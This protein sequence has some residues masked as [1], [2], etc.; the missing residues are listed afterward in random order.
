MLYNSADARD[1]FLKE[2]RT[3]Y[4]GN[5]V[6]LAKILEFEQTYRAFDA[7]YWY[8]RPDF[9]FRII[10]RALRSGDTLILFK[11][12]YFLV[13]MCKNLEATA[14]AQSSL[15][16]H[17]YRGATLAK[18][19]VEQLNVGSRIAATS[20]F[21]SSSNIQV[22]RSF[23][24]IDELTGML[25]SRSRNDKH[26]FVLFEIAVKPTTIR[27]AD[28]I[29]ANVSSQSAFPEEEEVLFGLGT[30]FDITMIEYDV[31]HY[32]WNIKM[33]VSSEAAAIKCEQ[34]AFIHGSLRSTTAI[35]LFGS[36]LAD[37]WGQYTQ[38]SIYFHDLL[39]T[40]STDHIDRPHIFYQLGRVYRFLGKFETAIAYLRC[41]QLFQRRL[42]PQ[43][44]LDYGSTLG[45]LGAT[46]SKVGD[47]KRAVHS[48]HL[49]KYD[50]ALGFHANRLASACYQEKQ[51]ERALS[52]LDSIEIVFNPRMS[53]G[54]PG[55]AQI[56]HTRALV[57]QALGD[58]ER[59]LNYLK[60]ALSMRES[61]LSKDHP[62]VARTCYQLALLYEE[63]SEYRLAFEH[64]ERALRIQELKL[65]KTHQERI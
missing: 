32:L 45:A 29:V 57:Y 37:I 27:S 63:R 31:E 28:V 12:R 61:W 2:C 59:T 10:N 65:P 11:F 46:Y 50:R 44:T 53:V 7:I 52:V 17:V 33:D 40:L 58:S 41:I 3:I 35:C 30:T 20:F 38:A 26:Q 60:E 16:I 1:Q 21:S 9:L 8:T 55:L 64:A 62:A 22:A 47:S 36:I 54:H 5:S 51:Y 49:P 48:G 42:L 24:I 19:E 43:T 14:A 56:I 18:E 39:R 15:P 25:P 13:D 34:R 6:Q 4:R 23:I